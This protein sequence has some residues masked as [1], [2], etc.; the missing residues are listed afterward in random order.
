MPKIPAPGFWQ[1]LDV[2]AI[3]RNWRQ[4]ADGTN[5]R[6]VNRAR[7]LAMLTNA[8][9]NLA[10]YS[11]RVMFRQTFGSSGYSAGSSEPLYRWK[12]DDL[13]DNGRDQRWQI[14]TEPRTSGSGDSYAQKEP[15]AAEATGTTPKTQS[16]LGVSD[17]VWPQT[18]YVTSL[19]HNRGDATDVETVETGTG[20]DV[21][22]GFK[23]LDIVAQDRP[24]SAFDSVSGKHIFSGGQNVRPGDDVLENV[25][26]D[27]RAK[28][29][30]LR[31]T[32]LPIVLCWGAYA[33]ADSF[34]VTV[35]DPAPGAAGNGRGIW[36]A[37]TTPFVNLLD[38]TTASVPRTATSP[39]V[40]CPMRYAGRGTTTEDWGKQVTVQLRAYAKT[41]GT[42]EGY[43]KFVGPTGFAS[44]NT[45]ITLAAASGL[46]WYGSSSNK[47]Y[48]DSTAADTDTGTT[49]NKIDIQGATED[50]GTDLEIYGLVGWIEYA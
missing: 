28:L 20:L 29:H 36:V 3:C 44:N 26:D 33:S 34:A 15:E 38:F 30:T 16:V 10:G 23:V 21:F 50:Q 24:L 42:G 5:V 13:V 19:D 1:D 18:N 39:G 27:I 6:M 12:Y 40:N 17:V 49:R 47:I 43:I 7:A 25:I 35:S 2:D 9:N 14:L 46:A 22:N 8:V 11:P 4:N 31:T 37:D 41:T 48:L 45:T 32:N